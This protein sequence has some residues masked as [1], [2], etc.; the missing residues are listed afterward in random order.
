MAKFNRV[1]EYDCAQYDGSN[2]S[3]VA[4][5]MYGALSYTDSSGNAYLGR[6]PSSNG[7]DIVVGPIPVGS[8]VCH[9]ADLGV[10]FSIVEVRIFEDDDTGKPFGFETV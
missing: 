1:R 7:Q 4:T 3:D 5:T 2:L 10:G 6:G 9:P 8:W